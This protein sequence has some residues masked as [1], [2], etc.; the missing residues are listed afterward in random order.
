MMATVNEILKSLFALAPLSYKEE[1]D[2]VGFMLGH[3]DAPVRR[4]LVALDATEEVAEEAAALGCELVV[5]HHPLIFDGQKSVTDGSIV[6]RRVLAFA[7]RGVAVISMHTNLDCAPRGVNDRLAEVLGLHN[8]SVLDDG[9]TAGLIRTGEVEPQSLPEFLAF[10][11]SALH[12]PGLRYADGGREVRRVAVGGGSCGDFIACAHAAG[13]DTFV[14][15]DLKYHQFGDASVLGI[16]LIDAGHFETEDPVCDVVI[17]YLQTEFLALHVV[18]SSV[19][20]GC[21]HYL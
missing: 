18:K 8:V 19:H 14:T 4:V 21:I 1:F 7:D 9:E 13:C 20:T 6:G 15:A 16:N 12:C 11:K 5:T 10:V 2:N 17:D 3:G